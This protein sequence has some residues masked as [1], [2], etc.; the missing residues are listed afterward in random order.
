M[1]ADLFVGWELDAFV[2]WCHLFPWCTASDR[3]LG[4]GGRGAQCVSGRRGASASPKGLRHT[5][6]CGDHLNRRRPAEL[7]FVRDELVRKASVGPNDR[8]GPLHPC[9]GLGQRQVAALH[10]V[11]N[12]HG[13]GAEDHVRAN[14]M[15]CPT[16]ASVKRPPRDRSPQNPPASSPCTPAPA[17]ARLAVHKHA[18]TL[19]VG[20]ACSET[21]RPCPEPPRVR[22]S[23]TPQRDSVLA[24]P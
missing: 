13:C 14:V 8:P 7:L 19:A 1:G 11:R 15:A 18:V 3:A 21:N 9:V 24:D 5:S 23:W 16:D 4:S 17:H 20:I 2:E 10:Q 12:A 6:T 22:M